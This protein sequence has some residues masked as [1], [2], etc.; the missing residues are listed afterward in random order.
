MVYA[1][2]ENKASIDQTAHLTCLSHQQVVQAMKN[3]RKRLRAEG[4][5]E[6]DL[7]LISTIRGLS[8]QLE[9]I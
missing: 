2:K 6:A 7:Q 5:T 8:K 1:T 3:E 4:Y 9:D